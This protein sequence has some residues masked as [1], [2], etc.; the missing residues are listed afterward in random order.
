MSIKNSLLIFF[1]VVGLF[2]LLPGC[3]T[4]K[5][6]M[7]GAYTKSAEKNFTAEQV[8]A[9]FIFSH[10]RQTKGL[11][12]IPKLDNKYERIEGFDDFFQDALNEF[13]NLKSYDT[14]TDYSDDVNDPARRVKKD[15]LM[16]QND[17][18]L[19]IKF[20]R[21]KSFA[22]NF[23]GKIVSGLSLTLL[24]VPYTYSYSMNTDV[25]EAQGQ[26]LK[27]YSRSASLT[28]WVQTLL[29]VIY[30]FYPEQRKK[31][32]LYVQFMHDIFKQIETEKLLKKH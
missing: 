10:F 1:V 9:L 8:K 18:I 15:S 16:Q 23:L 2:L 31:E 5:S 29:I 13:S 6:E 26:L 20:M 17:Y 14:F 22:S 25:Y 3:A 21:T 27:N 19:K 11:D 4:F 7:K 32:E 24:P 28:K 30:P 12:A